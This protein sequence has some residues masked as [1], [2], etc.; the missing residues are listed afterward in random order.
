MRKARGATG[1]LVLAFGQILLLRL[2]TPESLPSLDLTVSPGPLLPPIIT[3]GPC[4]TQATGC[5]DEILQSE[6]VY[7]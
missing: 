6:A 2:E 3:R 5:K 1:R 7:L 4:L